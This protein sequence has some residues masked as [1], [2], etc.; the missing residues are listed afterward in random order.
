M[1]SLLRIDRPAGVLRSTEASSGTR[2]LGG[3]RRCGDSHGLL[4]V[5]MNAAPAVDGAVPGAYVE[6]V[7]GEVSLWWD[8]G[9]R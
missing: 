6:T 4:E 7:T 5:R 1:R 8:W 3:A 9:L 2:P